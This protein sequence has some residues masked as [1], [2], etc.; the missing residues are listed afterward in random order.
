MQVVVTLA[1]FI[2]QF[3]QPLRQPGF[4]AQVLMQPLADGIADGAGRPVIDLFVIAI[5]L[6]IHNLVF[7]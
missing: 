7:R 4:R 5:I 6:G 2:H 1:Q 3:A